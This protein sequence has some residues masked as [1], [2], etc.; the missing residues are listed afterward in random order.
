MN[1]SSH[2]SPLSREP[3]AEPIYADPYTRM[4]WLRERL[5]ALLDDALTLMDQTASEEQQ[6]EARRR[7]IQR[8]GKP[9]STRGST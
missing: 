8:H 3:D 1:S 2:T 5:D 6:M 4:A 7:I 9:V